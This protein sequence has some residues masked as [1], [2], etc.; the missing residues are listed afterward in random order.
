MS[1]VHYIGCRP[2]YNKLSITNYPQTGGIVS[3]TWM[4]Y[5]QT[6]PPNATTSNESIL[7]AKSCP[8]WSKTVSWFCECVH[9]Y[10]HYVAFLYFIE[11]RYFSYPSMLTNLYKYIYIYTQNCCVFDL[12]CTRNFPRL[13]IPLKKTLHSKSRRWTT[14]RQLVDRWQCGCQVKDRSNQPADAEP[15]SGW[16]NQRMLW[17]FCVVFCKSLNMC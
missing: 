12:F 17:G 9:V 14:V 11:V 3:W 5:T 4:L 8:E 6:V 15:T 7:E 13:V 10:L 2:N 16:T 1:V